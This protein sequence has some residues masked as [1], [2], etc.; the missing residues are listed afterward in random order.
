MTE[1]KKH[2]E[3]CFVIYILYSGSQWL[4]ESGHCKPV[5]FGFFFLFLFDFFLFMHFIMKVFVNYFFA[6]LQVGIVICCTKV[7]IT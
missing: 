6:T 1:N 2:Q 4:T 7:M 3:S 5:L